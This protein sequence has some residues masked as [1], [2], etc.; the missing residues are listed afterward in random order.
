[1]HQLEIH[2]STTLTLKVMAAQQLIHQQSLSALAGCSYCNCQLRAG[3]KSCVS[4][5]TSKKAR[6]LI[7]P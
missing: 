3:K 1:M 2:G 6:A 5:R 4:S 7:E